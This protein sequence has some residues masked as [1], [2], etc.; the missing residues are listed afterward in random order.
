MS[1]HN[2]DY[3]FIDR[4]SSYEISEQAKLK[5]NPM[6]S[7][8]MITYNHE[9]YIAQAIEGVLMQKTDFAIEIVIGEDCSTDRT[10][11]I[12]LDYQKKYPE[13]IRVIISDNNVGMMNNSKRTMAACRGKYIALCEGDDYWTDPL[14]LQ[15]QV[16]FLESNPDY[17]MVHTDA[18]VYYTQTSKL[19]SSYNI[20]MGKMIWQKDIFE[21]ILRSNYPVFTCTVLFRRSLLDDFN[22]NDLLQFKMGDT[23]FWLEFSRKGQILYVPQSTAVRQVL[24]ESATQSKDIHKLIAFRM[25]GYELYKYFINKYGCNPQTEKVVHSNSLKVI[26]DLAIQAN[27]IELARKSYSDMQNLCGEDFL[28]ARDILHNMLTY[29]PRGTKFYNTARL[30]KAWVNTH[31]LKDT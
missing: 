30:I 17:V 1:E 28:S 24:H 2:Q 9:S 4:I 26:L 27:D 23:F 31:L 29:L 10:R 22:L 19:V 16:D 8:L 25:S 5:S 20:A 15:K 18:D 21:N 6:V 14:K 12:V 13:L 11:E 7:V 3:K